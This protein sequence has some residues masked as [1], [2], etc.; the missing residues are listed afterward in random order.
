MKVTIL[1]TG[2]LTKIPRFTKIS[3]NE[4]RN[5]YGFKNTDIIILS[6]GSIKKIK[7]SDILLNSFLKLGKEYIINNNLKLLYIGDGPMKTFL[8]KIVEKNDF[9]EYVKFYG[10]ISYEKVSEIYKLAHIH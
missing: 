9:N 2:D 1:G 3:K 5:R 10:N 4:L 7:G 8:E 6:L